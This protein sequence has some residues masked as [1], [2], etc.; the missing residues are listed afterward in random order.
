M[1]RFITTKCSKF[2][3]SKESS[4]EAADR[5]CGTCDGALAGPS[6]TPPSLGST[7]LHRAGCG[8]CILRIVSRTFRIRAA[9]RRLTFRRFAACADVRSRHGTLDLTQRKPCDAYGEPS[10]AVSPSPWMNCATEASSSSWQQTWCAN[11]LVLAAI[12]FVMESL[13]RV[14]SC[15]STGRKIRRGDSDRNKQ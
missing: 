8:I 2:H 4:G 13:N 3:S 5:G 14:G 10:V 12:L 15:R 11:S 9:E 1:V 6:R 7:G